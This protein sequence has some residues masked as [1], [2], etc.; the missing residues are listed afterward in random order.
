MRR[1]LSS[2][3]AIALASLALVPAASAQTL[4]S[5]LVASGLTQPVGAYAPPGDMDRL[6]IVE[7]NGRIRILTLSSG[8][9]QST[10]TP[11]LNIATLVTFGG[12]RGLLGLAFH[13]NFAVNGYFY[14][15]YTRAGDGATVIARYQASGDPMT[16]SSANAGSALVLLTIAQPFAN[17][18]G[19]HIAFGPDGMLYAAMGDGG[20]ANDPGN[21]SQNDGMLLGK[22]LRLDIDDLSAADGD[23]LF[24]PDNNPFRGG[25]NPLDEIWAK[26]LRNPWKF[27]FDRANG[28]MYIGDVGQDAM[29]EI[30]FQPA[31]QLA[32]PADGN[33]AILNP[34]VAGRNYGWRCMEGTL[35]T[36][37]TGCTCNAATLTNP[38]LT[39]AQSTGYCSITGGVVYR[40]NAI[41]AL[42]GAYFYADYCLSSIRTFRQ[43]GGAATNLQD[44]TAQLAP[45]TG[46]ISSVVAFGE[47]GAGEVY[48]VSLGGNVYRIVD[49][50]SC[51]CPCEVTGADTVV[52]SFNGQADSGWTFTLPGAGAATDGFWQRGVPVASASYAF[53]PTADSDGSGACW[54]TENT[55]PG[56][57]GTTADVDGGTT[58]L[59]SPALDF[60]NAGGGASGGDITIC[61][62][63]Y[64]YLSAAGGGD[65]LFVDVSSNAAAGP[66]T[67]I[68]SHS[69]SNFNRWTPHAITQAELTA[70]GVSST[71]TMR[72]RFSATDASPDGTVECAVDNVRIYRRIPITDCNGNGV[73][74]SQDIA[75]G[76]SQD[77]NANLIPDE[78]DI[79]GGASE[80][81]DGGPT[82]IRAAGD[83]FFNTSCFGCHGPSGTGGTGPNIR[84]K[85]RT[86][87]RNRLLLIVPHPGGGFPGATDQDFAD[88]E[89]YLDDNGSG[90]R[91]DRIPDECQTLPNCNATGGN[92]GK[93][94]ALGTQVDMDYDGVPDDC[95]CAGS[96]PSI[97][98][99]PASLT[100]A[101][102]AT[103]VFGVGAT[104]PAPI[105]YQWR[106]DGGNLID[107][108]GISGATTDT[109]TI[110]NAQCADSGTIDVLVTNACG[111]QASAAASLVVKCPADFDD[112]SATGTPDCA[113][114]IADLLY[115]LALFDL[116]DLASDLDDGSATG[117][118]DG[119][120]D[121]ADLL[122]YLARFDGGC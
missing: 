56:A 4:R 103:A 1:T 41:P 122:Y 121:I 114:D 46:S 98:T 9:L 61:Y 23:G 31:L 49:G 50:A 115:Y 73:P 89:A 16:S 63:Y 45:P 48:I 74:D 70:A 3:V 112:G 118:P 54:V 71:A 34:A 30:D 72:V 35:C 69:A 104:S 28:D 91:P 88:I 55:D 33:S 86:V 111:T 93:E 52:Y 2:L 29:E 95:E 87:I 120:V 97:S 37:L 39:V 59:L 8:I 27:S 32:N 36:G 79:S 83:L 80:D 65:G 58:E 113:V 24:I 99:Q 60:L 57:G 14:V 67:R 15:N 84:N 13:P 53:D 40:G 26:G 116:G 78:C 94:L 76:T 17:H 92:D 110:A 96:P 51:G 81:Y 106:R 38:I 7:Q 11:Y 119:S 75:G 108:G 42:Q 47:D 77:C 19:G 21:R 117:T 82:G 66:W 43:V 22:M 25:G 101:P 44:W 102:G 90:A 64:A 105:S 6:F 107:A 20:S 68:A 109:L 12:E 62:D 100:I 85:S 5:Q 10:L 18:N